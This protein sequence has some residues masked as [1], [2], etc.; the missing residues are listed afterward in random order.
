MCRTSISSMARSSPR[1]SRRQRPRWR[2]LL[3]EILRGEIEPLEIMLE[4]GLLTRYY[5]QDP[6]NKR[7]TEA[8]AK[9]VGLLYDCNPDIRILEIGGGTGSATLPVLE[10]MEQA[11]EGA[12]A[13]RPLVQ[14]HITYKKLDISQDPLSQGFVAEDYDL[15]IAANVLHATPD[16]VQTIQNTSMLLKSGGKLVLLELTKTSLPLAFPFASLPGWWLSEDTYRSIDG[17]LLS[18]DS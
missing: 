10:A 7:S 3:L 18:E 15:I 6:A 2:S 4:D 14:A 8:L 1:P 5:E 9:Y 11:L 17:P 12:S 13:N 16:I